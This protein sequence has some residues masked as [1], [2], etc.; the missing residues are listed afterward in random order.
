MNSS[1][2]GGCVTLAC[3]DDG[4]IICR[5]DGHAVCLIATHYIILDMHLRPVTS[6]SH[7]PNKTKPRA[8]ISIFTIT[9]KRPSFYYNVTMAFLHSHFSTYYNLLNHV[10]KVFS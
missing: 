9:L 7:T 5:A 8:I 1:E 10:F 2:M 4:V 6:Y 3:G